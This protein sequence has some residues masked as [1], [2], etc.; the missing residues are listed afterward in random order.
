VPVYDP[1][2]GA[3]EMYRVTK[4]GGRLGLGHSTEPR[5][6]LVKLVADRIEA[7]AWRFPGL[8]MGCRLVDVLPALERAGARVLLS[9]HIGVPLWPFQ[10]LVIEK[11][12]RSK[13]IAP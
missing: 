7:V 6:K 2:Q 8:S 10:I 3:L 1:E 5:S 11:P 13:P 12:A 9:K 4:P